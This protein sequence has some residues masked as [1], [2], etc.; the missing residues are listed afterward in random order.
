AAD[1]GV[2][3]VLRPGAPADLRVEI[4]DYPAGDLTNVRVA[5][6]GF[7][8]RFWVPTALLRPHIADQAPEP[9]R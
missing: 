4:V 9:T 1:G 3:P 7:S 6:R 5:M 8:Q 2:T